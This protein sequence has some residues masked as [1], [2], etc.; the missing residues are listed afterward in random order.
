MD[1]SDKTVPVGPGREPEPPTRRV[2]NDFSLVGRVVQG[3]SI[4]RLI[5]EGGMGEVYLAEKNFGAGNKLVAVKTIRT[6]HLAEIGSVKRFEVEAYAAATINSSYVIRVQEYGRVDASR[7]VPAMQYLAM[8]YCRGGSLY[9]HLARC[10][11]GRL[12]Y[13]EAVR[14]LR[15]AAQGLLAAERRVVDGEHRPLVHRDIK[16][17]NLLLQQ[18]DGSDEY[19]LRIADFGA[20]KRDRREGEASSEL[21]V[22]G[23]PMTPGYASP[24]QWEWRDA[25]HKSD[26]YALGAT[27]YHALTGNRAAPESEHLDIIRKFVVQ[28]PCLSPRAVLRDVPAPLNQVIERMTARH[29]EDRY[30]SF[31][32][33]DAALRAIQY[34]AQAARRGWLLVVVAAALLLAASLF[35]L[36]GGKTSAAFVRDGYDELVQR[37][38]ALRA[39]SEIARLPEAGSTLAGIA[40]DVEQERRAVIDLIANT[41]D[42]EQASID[43]GAVARLGVLQERLAGV[44]D[45]V[46]RASG[47]LAQIAAL[48]D[49]YPTLS[50][51][52]AREALDRVDVSIRAVNRLVVDLRGAIATL[53]GERADA[54][55]AIRDD[56]VAGA[57]DRGAPGAGVR[58]GVAV[59]ASFV[60]GLQ[61][62]L[63]AFRTGSGRFD[64]ALRDQ[65]AVLGNVIAQADRFDRQVPEW[66][67][68]PEIASDESFAGF[69]K[70]L[71]RVC[72]L[73]TPELDVDGAELFGQWWQ[74]RRKRIANAW[75]PQL[76]ALLGDRRQRL[77]EK[78]ARFDAAEPGTVRERMLRDELQ[79]AWQRD[80]ELRDTLRR[81]LGGTVTLFADADREELLRAADPGDEPT[82]TFDVGRLQSAYAGVR[83]NAEGCLAEL[84]AL[85]AGI[86]VDDLELDQNIGDTEKVLAKLDR[87]IAATEQL[88]AAG[89]R[90]VRVFPDHE[91]PSSLRDDLC[92]NLLEVVRSLRREFLRNPIDDLQLVVRS[93][94]NMRGLFEDRDGEFFRVAE[95]LEVNVAAALDLRQR[96][97]V[98]L[99]TA[100]GLT[101]QD[102]AAL[103]RTLGN[104][105]ALSDAAAAGPVGAADGAVTPDD[106]L[107]E[108]ARRWTQRQLAAAVQRVIAQ[109]PKSRSED[110]RLVLIDQLLALVPAIRRIDSGL[111]EALD[112]SATIS[113][114]VLTDGLGP[115]KPD[116][117]S[118]AAWRLWP[119]RRQVP[120][121]LRARVDGEHLICTF[122]FRVRRMPDG[123]SRAV[124][125]VLVEIDDVALLVDRHEVCVGELVALLDAGARDPGGY[126]R[127][128][129]DFWVELREVPDALLSWTSCAM[130]DGFTRVYTDRGVVFR[131]PTVDEWRSFA[132][133]RAQEL[134][135]V[136]EPREVRVGARADARGLFGIGCGLREWLS[137]GSCVDVSEY[138]AELSTL[139]KW[140][141]DVGFRCVLPL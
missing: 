109:L 111:A 12:P 81:A 49:A 31:A 29:P 116:D 83:G 53:E 78:R 50:I 141:P 47:P 8:E 105:A 26:M 87:A 126:L 79:P 96:F 88:L 72:E 18:L 63:D 5:G 30:E 20:V 62:R 19:E 70:G 9:D 25:D 112:Q 115:R 16:P 51:V 138:A 27:F 117:W 71:A 69:V 120:N 136:G 97:V 17:G 108:W 24:E 130:A 118:D 3:Y 77:E 82:L 89:Q 85:A 137:D 102:V 75:R 28:A 40:G 61:E 131:L 80:A 10:P 98:E 65:A 43:A 101:G 125:M 57:Q 7:D 45:T 110:D 34:P 60:Q 93:L 13:D 35:W 64:E 52:D 90:S 22:H 84:R 135:T 103:E 106:D 42:S 86:E 38:G 2:R 122:D 140:K 133:A 92:R 67:Y 58:G 54:L 139:A 41:D 23:A 56:F 15:Q 55:A 1:D 32:D 121:G 114:G 37:I 74:N 46:Q 113:K 73:A 66:S 39:R 76:L 100:A 127:A 95:Q 129:R 48:R 124:E 14:L 132:N 134:R 44:E 6:R 128:R 33:V 104:V 107:K 4:L 91:Q 36:Q 59:E 94:S 68:D 99:P 123:S 21:S 11:D 119:K